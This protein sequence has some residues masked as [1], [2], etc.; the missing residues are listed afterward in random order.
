MTKAPNFP[1]VGIGASAGGVSAMEGLFRGIPANCGMAFVIVTHLSPDRD[2]MLHKVVGRY[3]DIPVI[4]AEDG[5]EIRPDTVHVMPPGVILKVADRRLKLLQPGNPKRERNPID[6]FFAALAED[7]GE[8]TVGIVLSGGDSD[9]TLGVK[10]IK[11]HG[12][13]TMAQTPDDWGPQHPDMPQSAIGTGIVDVAVPAAE[14]GA[15]LVEF[16]RSFHLLDALEDDDDRAAEQGLRRLQDEIYAILRSHSGHDFSGYKVKTFLRRVR[17][18]MQLTQKLSIEAYLELL[19]ASSDEVGALFRDLMINVTNF[20]RDPEAFRMLEDT[21]IP[22]LFA[23]RDAHDTIRI[24]VPGCATGEEVFSI[25]MLMREHLDRMTSAPRVQIFATDIDD[26]ALSVARTARYPEPLLA[27]ISTE[28]RKRFFTNDGSSFV[29]AKS[30][31][32]LCIFSA[33]SVIR[34]PPFS[35]MDMVSCR[36][37]LIYFGPDV[38]KQVIPT[39]HYSLKPGG[40]LF[41]GTSESVGP[42][43]DLFVPVDKKHRI[44]KAREHSVP[45]RPPMHL[46]ASSA[47]GYLSNN[48]Q[49]VRRTISS[50]LRQAVETQVLE[51]FAPAHVV[52]NAE[53]DIVY[54]SART[55]RYLEP[56]PGMPSRQLFAMARG[57]LRLE[58]RSALREAV[59]GRRTIIRQAVAMEEEDDRIQL[60]T[61]TVEPMAGRGEAEPLFLVL[62]EPVGPSQPRLEAYRLRHTDGA[63]LED[64]EREL[65]DTRERLQST[66]EEYET[67]LEELKSSNEELMSVNEEAQSANEE[68]EA[69]KEEMQSLNEE[70]NTINTELVLKIEELDRT[71]TDLKNLFES[72]RIATVFLDIKLV[73]RSF[74]PA[75]S[76]FFNLLPSD[77]GRPLTDLST[78]LD[79]PQL[80]AHI[81]EVFT[82]G[83]MIEHQLSRD[84]QGHHYLVRL[85][86]YR[87]E[88][89]RIQ[90]V[91]VTFVDVTILAEA[92]AYQRV[93]IGELNHRVKNVLAVTISMA[94][95]TLKGATS[96]QAYGATLNGRL[97]AMAR[98]YNM[99]SRENWKEISV[100]EIVRQE[101][102]PFGMDRINLTGDDIQL[103]PLQGLSLGLVIHELVTNAVKY[104]ALSVDTGEVAVDWSWSQTL[105]K[106]H[107]QEQGGPEPVA[108]ESDGFGLALVKGEIEYRLGG[109][110]D[111][112]FLTEGLDLHL[113]FP[114]DRGD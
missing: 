22:Q 98:S 3:T 34:D 101:L 62:F 78:R 14:M 109:R 73:I 32:D 54:F 41:L 10:V 49:R 46:S 48:D 57:S 100:R 89:E 61:L 47:T 13:L 64:L 55:G 84:S 23:G 95:Q 60:L 40:F 66:V 42:H 71:N 28:R 104:G 102:E 68:M 51:R 105:F 93:L 72:T 58:L 88:V 63:G 53:G 70:L 2:S 12:G 82:S 81:D 90:G 50:T 19:R 24:W 80:R 67:A 20:F 18:R 111:A 16:G 11:E 38:Q 33:H 39:F 96:V 15:K 59:E 75:A 1:I 107:W 21:I 76:S 8:Y 31:R 92:E 77:V 56:P 29:L 65:R 85:I 114:L 69:S 35:R 106:L 99:L 86:P 112:R 5:M 113:S 97:H 25:G 79:Y 9:G 17:R 45:A 26:D 110:I 43:G 36:N 37:L 27:G 83:R 108:P 91:V 87:D 6:I 30:V 74:T 52:V 44:F 7:H 4:V 103:P 94:S